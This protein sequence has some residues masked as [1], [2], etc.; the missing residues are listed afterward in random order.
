MKRQPPAILERL[1]EDLEQ[2][3]DHVFHLLQVISLR[4]PD[5]VVK[6]AQA[7]S[8][9]MENYAY[10]FEPGI[11]LRKRGEPMRTRNALLTAARRYTANLG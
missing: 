2:H 1:P 10:G 11:G 9:A 5:D 4:A 8:R 3:I 6:A 7:Y